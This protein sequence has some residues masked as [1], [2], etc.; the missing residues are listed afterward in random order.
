[1]EQHF[2]KVPEV[3]FSVALL[4]Y[5]KVQKRDHPKHFLGNT[6]YRLKT[7]ECW[8][9]GYSL[10]EISLGVVQQFMNERLEHVSLGTAHKD[11]STLR[12]MLNKA[13][14]EGLLER[15]PKFPKLKPL[16]HRTRWLLPEEEDRL[17]C[18]AAPH[19]APLIRF[20]V[21]TGGRRSELLGLD[22]RQV[23]MRNRRI[24]FLDTKNGEDRTVRL[25]DRA[26]AVLASIDLKDDGSVF[27]YKG[28]AIASVKRAFDRARREANLKDVRFHDLRHT[29]ASRL[30]QD[31]VP[32]Y[33]VM[34]MMG[35]KSLAMVQRYAHLAPDYQDRAVQAL[36]RF[37]HNLDT[38][39]RR[40]AAYV[41]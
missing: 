34:H 11:V 8:F 32:L 20:A 23:D 21:D 2:G 1:M 35:H 6:R 31:G 5:A 25:C 37:G 41:G 29:F 33:D 13:H 38:V 40:E 36:N 3:P 7:L 16:K 12:A 15:A 4:N 17:V 19:L 27:T 14:R 10:S 9:R 22:W 39:P 26:V 28:K 24:T 18:A 30:V